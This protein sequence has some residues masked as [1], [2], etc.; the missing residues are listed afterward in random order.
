VVLSGISFDTNGTVTVGGRN[1][2]VTAWGHSSVTCTLPSGQG[3]SQAVVLTARTLLSSTLVGFS[4]YAPTLTSVLPALG[5]TNG[6]NVIINLAG[7]DFGSSGSVAVDGMD[8]PIVV[9][10]WRS[11]AIQCYAPKGQGL[12]KLVYVTVASQVSNARQWGYIAPALG[13]IFPLSSNTSG[14]VNITL[15]GKPASLS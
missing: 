2:P 7:T 15:T 10:Q 6:Q 13:S 3:A 12:G 4:Y 11:T 5:A 14:G 9:G 8:C 1:C